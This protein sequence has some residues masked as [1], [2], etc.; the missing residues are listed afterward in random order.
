MHRHMYRERLLR[1]TTIAS[2]AAL[3]FA[4]TAFA[5]DDGTAAADDGD[6][7]RIVVT[8]SRIARPDYIANSPVTTVGEAEIDLSGAVSVEGLLNELPQVV[9]GLSSTSNNPGLNG[10]ATVDLR[11]LGNLRTLV[12]I[13]GRRLTPSDK[14]GTVDLNM[15][16]ATL[17]ERVE[18]VTGGTSAVYGSDAVAGV[19]NF[20]LKD[21]FEGAEAGGIYGIS[22]QGDAQEYHLDLTVGGD[23][24]SG[25]GNA[26]IYGSY[27]QRDE[28]LQSE[29]DYS[30]IALF[31]SSRTEQG[32]LE[33]SLLNP[34]PNNDGGSSRIN[35]DNAGNELG[36]P[37]GYNFAPPNDLVLP[38]D[39]TVLGG[40][41]TYDITDGIEGYAQTLFSDSR[42]SIQLAPTPVAASSRITV[43]A[44][45]ALS[46]LTGPLVQ[47]EILGR[48]DPNAPLTIQRRM[49]EVGPR[50]QEFDKKTYQAILGAN[51]SLDL[52]GGWD[53]D[54]FYSFS[55]SDMYDTLSNDINRTLF[56]QG[57]DGCLAGSAPGC[58]TIDIF[59]LG[60]ITPAQADYIDL[61]TVVDH[62]AYEQQVLS[63]NITGEIA[64]LPAGALSTAFGFEYR[65]DDFTFDPDDNSQG[66]II[67]FNAVFP[68]GGKVTV[69]EF[70]GEALVPLISGVQGIQYLGLE[71]GGRYSNYSS[72]GD[73]ETYKVGGEWQVVDAL[74]F[75]AMY[76]KAT[77][78]PSVFELFQAGDQNFPAYTD[79]CNAGGGALFN[80]CADWLGL[81][82]I[83]DA[84]TINAFA[85]SDGQVETFLFGTP[86]LDS[87]E[88]ETITA[89]VVIAP[90]IPFGDLQFSVDYYDI[91]VDGFIT[92][93]SANTVISRC[94]A[95]LNL[96]SSACL[97]TPRLPSGQLGGLLAPNENTTGGIKTSGY[98]FATALSVDFADA[99]IP[100]PGTLD[101][102]AL[103]TY[104]EKFDLSGGFINGGEYA[105][106]HTGLGGAFPEWKSS[107]RATWSF[108]DWQFSWQWERIGEMD[109]YGYTALYPAYYPALAAID[110]HD[111]SIRWFAT[112]SLDASFVCE[113]CFDKQPQVG[114]VSGYVSGP[115]IDASTYDPLGRYYRVG[116][117]KR[118]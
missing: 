97:A 21:N 73:V 13:D 87:E 68:S 96:A 57:L 2:T 74:R 35:I 23:F 117:R 14:Q 48:P 41:V 42:T 92:S 3:M 4:P 98:D 82:P 38:A 109:D 53:W 93:P 80:F 9:P 102:N 32:T 26:T 34:F 31:P 77:R 52:Y 67:G 59:G 63:A 24:A 110:Y 1:S 33:N 64:Q 17:V 114:T 100:L 60:S 18:V 45:L 105:G 71:L 94:V 62:H 25:R 49:S 69:R 56:Q 39:R 44:A 113:N 6:E 51:G 65:S 15:I 84:A 90:P 108:N 89:G 107:V 5:Q 50:R 116:L 61:D 115:N 118:F 55:R 101:V 46:Q 7:E 47:A 22:D 36:G 16:P 111:L 76:N 54:A 11:G 30:Q 86:T 27:F 99:G 83:A 40:F 112:E 12:L 20:I 88:S 8:G 28:L 75:R 79:P 70:Y 104:L 81:D 29:R 37:T 95:T 43:P 85:Q 78:A 103:V 106:F 66:N 72:V 19:V 58:T 10:Q 91:T